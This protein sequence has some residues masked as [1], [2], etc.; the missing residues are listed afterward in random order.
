MART[1]RISLLLVG[2][3]LAMSAGVAHGEGG[4]TGGGLLERAREEARGLAE[5]ASRLA[6][7]A[8]AQLVDWGRAAVDWTKKKIGD[9][10]A[11]KRI[12]VKVRG[13]PFVRRLT[14]AGRE[15]MHRLMRRRRLGRPPV[16]PDLPP[17]LQ[18]LERW[19]AKRGG[20]R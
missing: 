1:T 10:Q 17:F 11:L 3:A 9:L 4:R 5:A 15:V 6:R 8:A 2:L 14:K 19:R 13:L 20:G 16:T 18:A 12:F 7:G